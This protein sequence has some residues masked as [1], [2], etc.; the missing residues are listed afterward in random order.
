MCAADGQNY[1]IRKLSSVRQPHPHLHA[2]LLIKPLMP[3]FSN[4]GD[5]R[6]VTAEIWK[7]SKLHLSPP[8]VGHKRVW[9]AVFHFQPTSNPHDSISR[10]KVKSG[11]SSST[12]KISPQPFLPKLCYIIILTVLSTILD[13]DVMVLSLVSCLLQK[14]CVWTLLPKKGY[15]YYT[16]SSLYERT[17]LL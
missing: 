17:P 6:V 5:G 9:S 15:F 4:S 1:G 10:L 11:P 3:L 13:V 12:L 8:K 16:E 2:S 14:Y 7:F